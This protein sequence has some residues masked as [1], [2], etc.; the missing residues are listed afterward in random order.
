MI[1]THNA[2]SVVGDENSQ[3][4]TSWPCNISIVPDVTEQVGECFNQCRITQAEKKCGVEIV[5]VIL[6]VTKL[7]ALTNQFPPS[8]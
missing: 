3:W 5:E 7:A 4:L 6:A 8:F 1:T 2:C